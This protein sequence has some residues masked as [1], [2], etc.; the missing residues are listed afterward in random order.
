MGYL[1]ARLTVTSFATMTP[2]QRFDGLRG[3]AKNGIGPQ[4]GDLYRRRY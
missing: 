1:R 3:G 4:M 2:N